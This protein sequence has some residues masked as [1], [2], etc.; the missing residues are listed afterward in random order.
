M[1]WKEILKE[2]KKFI[3]RLEN[4]GDLMSGKISNISNSFKKEFDEVSNGGN[5]QERQN[6]YLF[7]I[8][9]NADIETVEEF[10]RDS[11]LTT[12]IQ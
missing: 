3:L 10:I 6:M 1:N 11:A 8:D 2:E 12:N 9:E 4:G 7:I 5:I